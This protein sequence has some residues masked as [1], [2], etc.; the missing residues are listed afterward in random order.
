ML[1]RFFQRRSARDPGSAPHQIA[2]ANAVESPGPEWFL[3]QTGS[4]LLRGA[5]QVGELETLA[6]VTEVVFREYYLATLLRVAEFAQELPASEAHHHAGRRGLLTHLLEVA[7]G[8]LRRRR[9]HF[10]PPGASPEEM[11]RESDAWTF[12][13]FAAAL[14]HDIGKP[15]VDQRIEIYLPSGDRVAWN[16]WA[17]SMIDQG[18]AWYRMEFARGGGYQLHERIVPLLAPRMLPV[19]AYEWIVAE[20]QRL[21]AWLGSLNADAANGGEIYQITSEADHDS[22]AASLTGRQV[23]VPGAKVVPLFERLI[24]ALRRSID[25]G[26]FP[27]NRNGAGGWLIGDDLWLVSKRVADDLRKTMISEGQSGVPSKNLRIFDELLDRGVLLPSADGRAVWSASVQGDGWSHELTL[28]RAQASRIWTNGQDGPAQFQGLVQVAEAATAALAANTPAPTPAPGNPVTSAAVSGS[29]ALGPSEATPSPG[30]NEAALA[31]LDGLMPST[32]GDPATE[33]PPSPAPAAVEEPSPPSMAG[34]SP[35]PPANLGRQ[36]LAWLQ[37]GV[38]TGKIT[39]NST[40]ARVHVVAEGVLLVSPVIFR[41]AGSDLS[42]DWKKMQG[43][44]LKLK[45]HRQPTA[46]MNIVKYRVDGGNNIQGL[47]IG[48]PGIVFPGDCPPV[49]DMLQSVT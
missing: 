38:S 33:R 15:V 24:S 49:N 21:S 37:D 34:D 46:G 44:F 5:G 27:M 9:A 18:G 20:P 48:D 30:S 23:Q 14:L 40:G 25:D 43:K 45:L 19:P 32:Q 4:E 29:A 10:L 2:E 7:T 31:L 8:A 47:L 36:F 39:V 1:P 28:V 35:A 11:G 22:T 26:S 42:A 13:V 17:G 6:G 3:V 16:P 41:M 12:A